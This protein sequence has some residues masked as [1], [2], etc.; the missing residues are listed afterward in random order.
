MQR[1]KSVSM[2]MVS[3]AVIAALAG[4][5]KKE[6]PAPMTTTESPFRITGSFKDIMLGEINPAAENLWTAVS[7]QSDE[8]GVHEKRPQ[9]DEDWLALRHQAV[10]LTEATNL[11]LMDG[12]P[13]LS[14]NQG[15][16]DQGLPG[17]NGPDEIHHAIESDRATFVKLVHALQDA[18]SAALQAIEKKDVDAL[19][20]AGSGIDTA[21]ENC[22]L[23]YWYPAPDQAKAKTAG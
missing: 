5:G 13:I 14:T 8:A 22:H 2:V 15:V 23:K 7:T 1:Y 6:A 17:I 18:G 10:I 9:T 12:R 4:C 21:C 3:L 16:K 11:L 19:I 20:E